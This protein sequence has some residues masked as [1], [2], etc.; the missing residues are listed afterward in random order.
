V[1]TA[2]LPKRVQQM[3]IG[4]ISA[5]VDASTARLASELRAVQERAEQEDEGKIVD[6]L[7]TAAM[8]AD[9][10]VLGVTDTLGAIHE[11]R[12]YRLIV[13]RDF[14]VEGKECSSCHVLV[15]NGDKKCSFC[16]GKLDPAPD[17]I[18]RASRRVLDRGGKVQ[19]VSG[20]AAAK[21]ADAGIGAILRF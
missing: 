20:A 11:G 6:S 10:A 3:I 8:K 1:F 7:I 2:E 16:G 12:V 18:N 21:L 9:R 15:A 17:L 5:P 14:R 4:A 19:L 13:A